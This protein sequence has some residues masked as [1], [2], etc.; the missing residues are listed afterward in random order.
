MFSGD[1]VANITVDSGAT[2]NFIQESVAREL[3]LR[4]EKS[5]QQAVQADGKT[6]LNVV[7]EV[8]VTFTRSKTK[9]YFDGL[10]VNNLDDD[11]LGGAPFQKAN[12]IMTDF[13]N[14]IFIVNQPSMKCTFP[15][16]KRQ[17]A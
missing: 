13:V 9:F 11:I 17:T 14:E 7:G 8:H 12:A 6:P 5:D 1:K 2:G 4:I 3:G 10:V 16:T 15:F